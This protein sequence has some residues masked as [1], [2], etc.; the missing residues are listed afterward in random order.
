MEA[1]GNPRLAPMNEYGVAEAQKA[2]RIVN[3]IFRSKGSLN[4]ENAL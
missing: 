4:V 1:K 3:A 2:F